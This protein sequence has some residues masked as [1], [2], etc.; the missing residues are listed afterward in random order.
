MKLAKSFSLVLPANLL[1][2]STKN[3]SK[4]GRKKLPS[5]TH[6]APHVHSFQFLQ[7]SA[8]CFPSKNST[9][10]NKLKKGIYMTRQ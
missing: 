6:S 5:K 4:N 9:L 7:T 3:R 10:T 2:L 8:P 1:P